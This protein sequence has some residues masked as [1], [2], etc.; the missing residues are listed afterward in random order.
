MTVP[1]KNTTDR[2]AEVAFW[3]VDSTPRRFAEKVPAWQ[4][5][6]LLVVF[7]ALSFS[8][9]WAINSVGPLN[10]YFQHNDFIFAPA[11]GGHA[12]P[13]RIYLISFLT[14]FGLSCDPRWH[15]KLTMT[16]EMVATYAL[17]C[18]VMD[19]LLQLI[20]V[21]TGVIFTLHVVEIASG[22]LGFAI[23]SIKLLE[24][25]KMPSRIPRYATRGYVAQPQLAG[26][27]RARGI[28]IPAGLL[29]A[30]VSGRDC[31]KLYGPQG[32]FHTRSDGLCA[33]P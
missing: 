20:F 14:A 2:R 27:D 18:M 11:T 12:V 29:Y 15:R 21:S 23:F 4:A 24:H 22:V 17:L 28:L 30:A 6:L 16:L 33:G 9:L 1:T 19:L 10:A 3:S 32:R 25:G 13:L 7:S 31:R 8:L 5:P 26:G